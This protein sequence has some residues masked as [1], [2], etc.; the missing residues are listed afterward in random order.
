MDPRRVVPSSG[1]DADTVVHGSVLAH[2]SV[3]APKRCKRPAAPKL[4]KMGEPLPLPSEDP[5]PQCVEEPWQ[6]IETPRDEMDE[7]TMVNPPAKVRL[8]AYTDVALQK[9]L[10][11]L[12]QARFRRDMA[13]WEKKEKLRNKLLMLTHEQDAKEDDMA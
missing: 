4:I 3:L 7:W 5:C 11:D 6:N 13:K 2:E 1:C 9:E 8:I 12:K 10:D